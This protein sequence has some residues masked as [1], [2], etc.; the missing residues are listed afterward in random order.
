MRDDLSSGDRDH[1]LLDLSDRIVFGQIEVDMRKIGQFVRHHDAIHN[2]GPIDCKGIG[3]R[4]VQLIWM[5]RLE[6]LAPAGAGERRKIRI[7]EFDCFPK[8]RQT[9][10]L[11]LQKNEPKAGI[12]EDDDLHW[13]LV[14]HRRQELAHQHVETTITAKGD[15]LARTVE[16]LDAVGLAERSSD[17]AIVEGP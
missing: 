7:G 5:A 4:A 15:D 3:D 10:T 12:V 13:Q 6:S 8:S 9:N 2:R 16:H 11:S 1:G 14:M 17:T